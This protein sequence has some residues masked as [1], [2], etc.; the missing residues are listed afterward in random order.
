M[1][2]SER[3]KFANTGLLFSFSMGVLF[4]SGCSTSPGNSSS[5]AQDERGS[6]E[7]VQARRV[8]RREL[9][10][11]PL[12]R[13]VIFHTDPGEV[14]YIEYT[15]PAKNSQNVVQLSTLLPDSISVTYSPGRA[16]VE[17]AWKVS[18]TE[19]VERHQYFWLSSSWSQSD[20]ERAASALRVLVV[21]ARQ[22]LDGM[23]ATNFEKF[24]AQCRSWR[25]QQGTS[26]MP[27]EARRHKVL[28]EN[29]AR[30]RDLDKAGDEYLDAVK[31]YPCWPEGQFKAASILGDTG[32][33]TGAIIHM[34]FYL[35][36]VPDAPDA[37]AVRDKIVVWQDKMSR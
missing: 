3:L 25:T 16:F 13:K 10:R 32:W 36:L 7:V 8:L 29:A 23:L 33:Y 9:E 14:P 15:D 19:Y 21:D 37:Q 22:Y 20:A 35:E 27:E 30:E 11:T 1:K 4:M 34:R 31:I 5:A 17:A 24:K 2:T 18:Y 6:P 26:P 12:V 28:A